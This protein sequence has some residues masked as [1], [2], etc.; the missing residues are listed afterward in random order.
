MNDAVDIVW[1]QFTSEPHV[2]CTRPT[3]RPLST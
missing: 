2:S 3:S 1:F